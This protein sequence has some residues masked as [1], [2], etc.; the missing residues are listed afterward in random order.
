MFDYFFCAGD[1]WVLLRLKFVQKWKLTIFLGSYTTTTLTDVNLNR[2][3]VSAHFST[4]STFIVD[5]KHAD[6]S[7]TWDFAWVSKI[8]FHG[9]RDRKYRNCVLS[10]ISNSNL[11]RSSTN[12]T[13]V[14]LEPNWGCSSF[15]RALPSHGRG[16]GFDYQLLHIF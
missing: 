3:S 1:P 15:G 11:K 8:N 13:Q 10:L 14:R 16:T 12:Q 5:S 4:F 6:T 2:A 9:F 7:R